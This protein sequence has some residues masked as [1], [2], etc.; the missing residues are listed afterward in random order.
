MAANQSI[1]G[2]CCGAFDAWGDPG[3]SQSKE[4][5]FPYPH[6]CFLTAKFSNETMR[7]AKKQ[8]EL[9]SLQKYSSS[10][11]PSV[12][13]IKK[14]KDKADWL[15]RR[16]N[17]M[18]LV[19]PKGRDSPQQ[20]AAT[21]EYSIQKAYNF[22]IDLVTNCSKFPNQAREIEHLSE[23]FFQKPMIEVTQSSLENQRLKTLAKG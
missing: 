9:P 3:N 18:K 14:D 1:H 15:S 5:S 4:Y 2:Y 12:S 20:I 17:R 16:A 8:E 11:G 19:K 13:T 10:A 22:Y 21:E 23:E 6:S 7:I